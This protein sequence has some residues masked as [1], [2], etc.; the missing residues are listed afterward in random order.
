MT[1]SVVP[2]CLGFSRSI[3]AKRTS[4]KSTPLGKKLGKKE[5]CE[6]TGKPGLN[7]AGVYLEPYKP[8]F[9]GCCPSI[10]FK[11]MGHLGVLG[12]YIFI[13]DWSLLSF[14]LLTDH[15][16]DGVNSCKSFGQC[17]CVYGCE[18]HVRIWII[19][20]LDLEL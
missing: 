15:C 3:C 12:I 2:L 6:Q 8:P 5:T 4:W 20:M 13:S 17:S 7:W 1:S 10:C 19:S 11:N 16:M 18:F 14:L 9:L